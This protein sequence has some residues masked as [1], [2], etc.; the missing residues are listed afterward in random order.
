MQQLT[1]QQQKVL[2]AIKMFIAEKGYPPTVREIGSV[3]NL[4]SSATVHSHI[5]ILENKGYLSKK[6]G[7]NRAIELLVPNEFAKEMKDTVTIPLLND[8]KENNDKSFTFS[9]KLIGSKNETFMLMVND[10]L[11][12]DDD[13]REG[14]ILIVEKEKEANDGEMIV[15]ISENN[16]IAVKKYC[17]GDITIIVGKVIG[18]YRKF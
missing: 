7:S 5:K 18:L 1:G 13:I 15:V 6:R 16:K 3:L 10:E 17:N 14:D 11:I 4:S 8:K 9:K 2:N 12:I